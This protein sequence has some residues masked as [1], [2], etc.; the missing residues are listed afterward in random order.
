MR[1][2]HGDPDGRVVEAK[3]D[4]ARGIIAERHVATDTDQQVLQVGRGVAM[5][6]RGGW[7]RCASSH[8]FQC[9]C[10]CVCL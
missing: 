4:A 2:T 9:V 7:R 6:S 1:H 5:G 10:V 8:V 3:Q